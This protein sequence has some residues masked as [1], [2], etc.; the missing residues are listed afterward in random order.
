MNGAVPGMKSAHAS[1]A[2]DVGVAAAAGCGAAVASWVLTTQVAVSPHHL[3]FEALSGDLPST[4]QA[5]AVACVD[6]A[7]GSD[8][9]G[10]IS[11]DQPW[12]QV[13][14]DRFFGSDTVAVRVDPGALDPGTYEGKI[15]VEYDFVSVDDSEDISVE[16]VVDP[17][18][19]PPPPPPET[20]PSEPSSA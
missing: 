10:S 8:C 2:V 12:L 7:D 15:H 3:D 20:S 5:F 9:G 14:H 19:P 6:V 18:P 13:D 17:P 1:V 11:V 4:A 16:L